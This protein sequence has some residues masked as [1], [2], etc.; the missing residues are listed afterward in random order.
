MRA[1]SSYARQQGVS[2]KVLLVFPGGLSSHHGIARSGKGKDRRKDF[3]VEHPK[4]DQIVVYDNSVNLH[5]G[6]HG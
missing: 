3:S 2:Q 4:L 5:F 1:P 6:G